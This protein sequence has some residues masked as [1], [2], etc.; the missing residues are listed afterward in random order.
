MSFLEHLAQNGIIKEEQISSISRLAQERF[1]GNT[2]AALVEA[3]LSAGDLVRLKSDYYG[4]PFKKVDKKAI[5]PDFLK[6]IPED[7]AKHYHM[8]PIGFKDGVLEVGML[9][10]DNIQATDALQFISVRMNVAYKVFLISQDD[11]DTVMNSFQGISSEVDEALSELDVEIANAT[12]SVEVETSKD[13]KQEEKIVEDAPIIKIVAVIINH[14]TEG[15]ASDIHIENTGEQVK[16][17]FRVDGVLHTSLVLPLNVYSGIVARIKIL[18]KLRLDEKRKP[19]D[20]GFT[21]KV[22]GRKIDF[23]V[24]TL[25]TYYGEK[26]VMRILDSERGVLPLDKLELSDSNNQMSAATHRV[27]HR[28]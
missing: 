9:D 26:V 15:N 5:S 28:G 17:R 1:E 23:R 3:G 7:S 8:V 19:Q 11:Y 18:A 24:S 20:G 22:S 16:V 21:A 25:P 2:D 27:M 13:D 12:A 14:A 4:I 6:Y 10:P